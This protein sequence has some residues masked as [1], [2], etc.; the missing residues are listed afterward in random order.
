VDVVVCRC[1]LRRFPYLA[2]AKNWFHEP[3][4]QGLQVA[5]PHLTLQPWKPATELAASQLVGSMIELP[6]I[7]G[8]HVA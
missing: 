3:K 8:K 5:Q 2:S 6:T 4:V 1:Q 7:C